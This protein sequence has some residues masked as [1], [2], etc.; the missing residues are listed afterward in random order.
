MGSN[1]LASS[2]SKKDNLSII[3]KLEVLRKNW[4]YLFVIVTINIDNF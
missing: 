2:A 1:I 4:F 3:I